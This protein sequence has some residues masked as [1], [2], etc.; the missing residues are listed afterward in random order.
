M[1]S[2]NKIS[3]QSDPF[4]N[5]EIYRSTHNQS[6]VYGEYIE[7]IKSGK[8]GKKVHFEYIVPITLLRKCYFCGKI[9]TP[10]NIQ[11]RAFFG[12]DTV[13]DYKKYGFS[14]IHEPC[15]VGC[16]NKIRILDKAWW[17]HKENKKLIRELNEIRLKNT[18][19]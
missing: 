19:K 2:K 11:W 14:Y 12:G 13:H 6:L 8:W 10:K 16:W 15:C 4:K 17:I 3:W 7:R 1:E 9:S 5:Q 18:T